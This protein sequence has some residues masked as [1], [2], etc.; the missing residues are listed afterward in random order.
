MK[1]KN[2]NQQIRDLATNRTELS[3]IFTI[4]KKLKFCPFTA[5][6][7]PSRTYQGLQDIEKT[8]KQQ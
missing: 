7:S 8:E 2:S 3:E 4:L 1:P 6:H 5:F